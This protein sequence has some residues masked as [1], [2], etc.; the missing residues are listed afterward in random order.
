MQA[1]LNEV[2]GV[3]GELDEAG[4]AAAY[5]PARSDWLRVNFVSSLDGAATGVDGRSGSIN[6]DADKQVFDLLRAQADALVVGAG[7]LRVEEYGVP[8]IPLV[9]VSRRGVVPEKLRDAEP[10]RV[11]LATWAGAEGREEAVELLGGDNVLVTGEHDMDLSRMCTLLRDRALR[12]LLSEGGPHLFHS[13]LA[14]GVVDELD[15]TWSPLVVAGGGPR[16]VAGS[17]LE[18]ELRPVL[19]LEQDATVL[20]RWLLSRD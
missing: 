3:T 15:L 1:L 10:G 2:T 13:L 12:Q 11:L 4:L 17:P 14:A 16:I 7:T 5:Q 9:V 20:G 6:N 18:L 19:L 8:R